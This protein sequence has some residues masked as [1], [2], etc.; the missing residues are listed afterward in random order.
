MR[1]TLTTLLRVVVAALA[2]S[3][4]GTAWAA[5][6]T[7]D[8]ATPTPNPFATYVGLFGQGVVQQPT[9]IAIGPDR[10]IWITDMATDQVHHFNADG[11]LIQ[12]FGET[13]QK[14]G[15]FEFADFGAVGLDGV[16]NVFVLDTGN[17]R[18]QKFT[19]D[20]TF[21]LEWGASGLEPGQFQHPSD[22]AVRGDGAVFVVD[23]MSGKVQQF[24]SS[25]TFVREVLPSGIADRFSEPARLGLDSDGNL[26]VP[27]LTRIYVIDPAGTLIRTIQTNE[28]GNG[29][30]YVANGAAVSESGFVYVS[31]WQSNT[32]SVF[33]P[34]GVFIGDFG[35]FG[36]GPGQFNEV[37]TLVTDGAGRLMVLDFV[38][39]RIQVFKL[40]ESPSAT[41][42]AARM[43]PET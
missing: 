14:P 33:D 30:I 22:I 32:V 36:T 40:T 10:S 23:A 37:D 5:T 20:L 41:P 25:G 39:K 27:D 3:L 31:D 16:G 4:P 13:G 18:V 28:T 35:G 7:A 21:E 9:D 29:T 24:D 6:P 11:K 8:G 12:T 43:Q 15:Q 17:E 19:P 1:A 42:V 26:Y 2:L 38:N 34:D